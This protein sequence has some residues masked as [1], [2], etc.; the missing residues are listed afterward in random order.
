[1]KKVRYV[2]ILAIGGLFWVFAG[3]IGTHYFEYTLVDFRLL[4]LTI[5]AMVVTFPLMIFT[6]KTL[7]A[8]K[9]LVSFYFFVL[10]FLIYYLSFTYLSRLLLFGFFC[11]LW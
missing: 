2:L 1:M 10:F 11:L 4:T 3:L 9:G 5:S 7:R 6:K 8:F